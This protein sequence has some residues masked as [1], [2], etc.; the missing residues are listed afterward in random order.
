MTKSRGVGRSKPG[1]S[2]PAYIHGHTTGGFS[3]TYHSW[4]SMLQRCTNTERAEYRRYGGRGI[5]VC[6]RWYLF[7]NF[8]TDMGERPEGTSLDRKN[9]DG[10]YTPRNCRWATRSEQQQNKNH[11]CTEHKKTI[12]RACKK[13]KT[14][15]ELQAI[16]GLHDEPTKKF[17]RELRAIGK[18]TT[19][20]VRTGT[21]GRTLLVA[22]V[23]EKK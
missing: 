13:P 23:K 15:A 19:S 4:A 20:L 5:T 9:N 14:T 11:K 8:L 16:L 3:R 22:T 10:N 1:S 7:Q 12:L 17:V 21:R 6:K 2:N 18:V